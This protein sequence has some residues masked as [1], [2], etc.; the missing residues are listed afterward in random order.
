MATQPDEGTNMKIDIEYLRI[1]K[2]LISW[3]I[4]RMPRA[5]HDKHGRNRNIAKRVLHGDTYA[6]VARDNCLTQGRVKYI[7][8]R[9]IARALSHEAPFNRKA[10]WVAH[11]SGI[12]HLMSPHRR[13]S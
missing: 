12:G 11:N 3:A 2:T 1:H 6:S 5:L 7:A 10:L 13:P 4:D 9:E 8:L